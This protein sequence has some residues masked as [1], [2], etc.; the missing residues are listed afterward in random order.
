MLVIAVPPPPFK[1]RPP[2][3]PKMVTVLPLA[4]V[5]VVPSNIAVQAFPE[6]VSFNSPELEERIVRL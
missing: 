5:I 4:T 2:V 1:V 3:P 6:R